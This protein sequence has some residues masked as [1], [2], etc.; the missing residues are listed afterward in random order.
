MKS[1]NSSPAILFRDSEKLDATIKL[2]LTLPTCGTVMQDGESLRIPL[3]LH[4]V[5]LY[6][7]TRKLTKEKYENT[8]NELQVELMAESLEWDP[9]SK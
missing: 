9:T 8:A 2:S 7:L 5:T 1:D 3:E 4:G 6:F